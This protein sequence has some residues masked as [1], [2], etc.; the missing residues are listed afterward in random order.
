[1]S[2]TAAAPDTTA[3]NSGL[4]SRPGFDVWLKALTDAPHR[5]DFY[6]VMRHI[7]AAHPTLPRLGEAL[8]PADEPLRLT[9]PAE[10]TFAPAAIHS[11]QRDISGAPRL[12]QRI[13]G[14]LGP[15]G[16]MPIHITELARD[17][18]NQRADAGLQRFLDT[19][20]HRFGLLFYRAWA[21]A[22]PVLGLDRPGNDPFARRLGALF[23]IGSE[24]TMGRDALGDHPKLHFTGRLGRQ[25]RDADGLLSWCRAEFGVPVQ[26]EQWCGHWMPLGRD[27]CTR[28]RRGQNHA[29]GRGAVLGQTV[30]DV[31][32][33]FRIVIGPLRLARYLDFLP[34]GRD[35]ARLQALVRQW[36]GLEFAWDLQLIL[37]RADVPRL[38]LGGG[39][40]TGLLG[41]SGWLGRYKKPHDA[42]DLII[43]VETTMRRRR[44]SPAAP[45]AA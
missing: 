3:P 45:A 8:R 29:L 18:I 38:Q 30:W 37:A 42:V 19:F 34:G 10:L 20:T 6:Q 41:R 31:Q 26:V 24:A 43:D 28:L 25:V 12:R 36:V 35:L 16:P 33:K 14:L 4:P 2:D 32:H 27:D 22:Q 1:M 15:N 13:F 21:Q 11:V 40:P 9:Q 17:R 23:G 44:T 7:D 39:R 5:Y